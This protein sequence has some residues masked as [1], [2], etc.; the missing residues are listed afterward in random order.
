M[1][2]VKIPPIFCS[3]PPPTRTPARGHQTMVL[4]DKIIQ[5]RIESL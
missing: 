1:K 4:A 3:E 5:L 2:G